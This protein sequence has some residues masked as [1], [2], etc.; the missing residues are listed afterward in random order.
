MKIPVDSSQHCGC[1]VQV[2]EPMLPYLDAFP[3]AANALQHHGMF[4][5]E[6][7]ISS[8]GSTINNYMDWINAKLDDAGRFNIFIEGR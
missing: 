1:L 6:H 4:H 7:K 8:S 3:I 5:I 2:P